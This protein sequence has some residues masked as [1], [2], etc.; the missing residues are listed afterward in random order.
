MLC[1]RCLTHAQ[2]GTRTERLEA[3]TCLQKHEHCVYSA[4]FVNIL[5]CFIFSE[6]YVNTT[7]SVW[8]LFYMGHCRATKLS[9]CCCEIKCIPQRA[10]SRLWRRDKWNEVSSS[11]NNTTAPPNLIKPRANAGKETRHWFHHPELTVAQLVRKFSS[12][13]WSRSSISAFTAPRHCARSRAKWAQTTLSRPFF[14]RLIVSFPRYTCTC[15]SFDTLRRVQWGSVSSDI[16]R[17]R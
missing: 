12:L 13:C 3:C 5:L 7:F 2:Q 16:I 14:I 11:K 4:R 10:I 17:L 6:T 8:V 15:K 1:Q 9:F